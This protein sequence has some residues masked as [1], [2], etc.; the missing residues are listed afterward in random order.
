M[1]CLTLG[2]ISDVLTFSPVCVQ[3]PITR[4]HVCLS[5]GHVVRSAEQLAVCV[6]GGVHHTLPL[7]YRTQMVGRMYGLND[8]SSALK[9]NTVLIAGDEET[10]Y[11]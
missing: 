3:E 7:L 6:D 5:Y 9:M 11:R 8:V 1:I 4:L 2:S 10:I